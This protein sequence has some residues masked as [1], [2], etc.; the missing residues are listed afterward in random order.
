LGQLCEIDLDGSAASIQQARAFVVGTLGAWHLESFRD[1]A[2]LLT[3]ELATNAVVHA[4][5]PFRL[6]VHFDGELTVEVTDGSREQP[7]VE[8]APVDG[9]RGRGLLLVS[10]I[11]ARWGSR[12]EG[13]G[14]TVWFTL[15][16]E[17]AKV[18]G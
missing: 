12:Q 11:A 2:V 7:R 10:E 16:R 5:T 4:R 6:S 8:D 9:D 1:R 13:E 3:S 15:T 17:R 14:K 18:S